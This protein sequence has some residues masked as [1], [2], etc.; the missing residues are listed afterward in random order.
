MFTIDLVNR[1]NYKI[2]LQEFWKYKDIKIL[3]NYV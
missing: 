3:K 2:E 1:K